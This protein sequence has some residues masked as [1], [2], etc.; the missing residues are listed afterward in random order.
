MRTCITRSSRRPWRKSR[1]APKAYCRTA[2]MGIRDIT[3]THGNRKLRNRTDDGKFFKAKFVYFF[4]AAS[5]IP[6][7][8]LATFGH[9]RSV[10]D[11]LQTMGGLSGVPNGTSSQT[12]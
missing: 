11:K 7:R 4:H 3:G 8:V 1:H 2:R 9:S 5:G 6:F 10:S 12:L